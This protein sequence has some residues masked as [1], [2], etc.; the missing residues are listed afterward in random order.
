MVAE[1]AAVQYE[2]K[3]RESSEHAIAV[4]QQLADRTV[5][6]SHLKEEL[7][8]AKQNEDK[9]CTFV[10]P[11]TLLRRHFT[12][13]DVDVPGCEG[14]PPAGHRMQCRTVRAQDRACCKA[15]VQS[16]RSALCIAHQYVNAYV[17][18]CLESA[19]KSFGQA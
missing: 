16:V 19:L 3:W 1:R 13:S 2:K 5:S 6:V 9:V 10:M 15:E 18:L 7:S 8:T 4:Q 17:S 14:S 11:H 12:V